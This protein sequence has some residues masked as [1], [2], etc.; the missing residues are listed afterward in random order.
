MGGGGSKKV[1]VLVLSLDSGTTLLESATALQV[2]PSQ[3]LPPP[4]WLMVADAPGANPANRPV[5]TD[6][7]ARAAALI[8]ELL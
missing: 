5:E 1:C 8:A 6:G 4:A 2:L 7:A 3:P